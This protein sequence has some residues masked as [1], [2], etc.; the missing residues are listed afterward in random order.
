M[1]QQQ[2]KAYDNANRLIREDDYVKIQG[3]RRISTEVEHFREF[4]KGRVSAASDLNKDKGFEDN[5]RKVPS[6]PDA[7]HN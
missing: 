7:L 3:M 6:C 1:L 5:K 4:F 2:N